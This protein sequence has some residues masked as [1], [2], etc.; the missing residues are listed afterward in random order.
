[1]WDVDG[2]PYIDFTSGV[3]VTNL[4]HNHPGLVKAIQDQAPRLM[5]TYSF[6]TPERVIASNRLVKTFPKNLNRVFMLSTGAEATEASLRIARRYTGKQEVLSFQGAFHG[7]TYGAMGVAGS[8]GARRGFGVPVPGGIVAPYGHCYRCFYDKTYPDCGMYCIKALDQLI[9]CSSSGD[10]GTVIVEP[11]QGSAGFIFP[12]DGW[13]SALAN[14]AK[15]RDL[16]LIVDE[17]QASF[18]RTGRMYAIEWEG[19]EP[20]MLCLGKGMGSGIPASAVAAEDRIFDC[21]SPGE[22]SSTW[23]G[24]PLASAAVLAV[25]DAM[26]EEQLP[27]RADKMGEYLKPR[28]EALQKKYPFLGDVRGRGLVFGLEIVK[29]DGG[30][31]PS[32]ELCSRIIHGAAERG[33]LLGKVGQFGNIIRVAPPLVILPEELDLALDVLETVFAQL[34]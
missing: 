17:V 14:W 16:V 23:G 6:H 10:L 28:L 3:L 30:K 2:N 12:P 5:N 15:E 19:I 4:G 8:R 27:Q 31:I 22:L 9:A 33:L 29:P 34:V 13:L 7:R 11:Y 20:N 21:M 18:G 1:V 25:L 24:N 26:E 32:P